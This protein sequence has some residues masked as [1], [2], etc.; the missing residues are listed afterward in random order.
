[1]F[2]KV[3]FFLFL[4]SIA[5]AKNFSV[6]YDPDYAP[7]SYGIDKK[8]YGL[9]VDIWKLWAKKNHHT[10][11]FVQAKD[12]DDA[13]L[14]VKEKKVDFFLGT[15]P[16]EKWMQAS[17]SYYKTKTALYFLK[18]F[19]KKMHTIGIIGDDYKESLQ[20]KLPHSAIISY[21]DYA[22]LLQSLLNHQ[23]DAIYDDALAISYYAIKNKYKHLIKES[24]IISDVSDVQAIAATHNNIQIFNE[25]FGKITLEE[26]EKIE[27]EWISDSSMR[28]YNNANF[29]KK[30][31]F[32]YVYDPDW[33]P[34]EYKDKMS[35]VH[36]GIIA[37]ILSLVSS[38]SGLIFHP[39]A[40]KTW[41]ESV[42]LLKAHKVDMVSAV[43]MTPERK[44]Y[45][46]FSKKNIY[47]Y[48]AVLVANKNKTFA[49][50]EDFND[51]TI[52]VVQGN[53]L[54]EWIQKRFP[55][56]HFIFF[57]NVQEGFEALQNNRIDFFGIN[58]VSATYYINV[59]GFSDCKIY[60]ILNYM[61][62]LKIA[63][64]KSVEP[65]ALALIDEAL[66]NI[67]Q[68]E[69]SDIYHKWTSVQIK[70]ERNYKL[71]FSI[72]AIA[73][74]IVLI[75]LF[76][77]KRLNRLVQKRTA[78]LKELNEHLEDKVIQRTQELALINK[79]MQ[80][81]IKYASLIQNA[82]LPHQKEFIEFFK[83]ASIIWEPKDTVGGDIYFFTPLNEE[84]AFLFVIDCTG[85]G[86]SGAF[87][88]MLLKA[89]EKQLLSLLEHQTLSPAD[90]LTYFN[91]TFKKVLIQ[92]NT[93][94]NV[95]FDAGVLY[96]NKATKQLRFAGANI[97]L[98]YLQETQLHTLKA[99]RHSIGYSASKK[100]Y[101]FKEHQMSLEEGMQFYITTDGFID[102]NGGTKGFPFGKK[103][104]F[105]LLC[106]NAKRPLDTQK[107][108]FLEALAHYQ[109]DEERNDDITLIALQII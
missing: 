60:T 23:V 16:Y 68:K 71:I 41:A 28:F 17:T 107:M 48:P 61:F 73:L 9:F 18:S 40:T 58:G 82:I 22:Q 67:T 12:W 3:L 62:H 93:N 32:R 98:Y 104:F 10:L 109:G 102:Q 57:N 14:L 90:I 84:E 54:G 89:I 31:E 24:R 47:D 49:I 96:I 15:T 2:S 38:K 81:N 39:V 44:K 36:M 25:G 45:L 13:L 92:E 29:L 6:S 43:P 91:H 56:S 79:K 72:I 108:L 88:T 35:H 59:V 106:K 105:E 19:H 33:K 21:T 20:K 55:Q 34:F 51:K 86:V 27:T 26:L 64:L 65:E 100:D 1:V 53:S 94:A 66:A 46:N 77:N 74:F 50:N 76:I 78:E 87:V 30:K 4:T 99:S 70:R 83:D 95:G 8:P 101:T 75:F 5:Y 52:G 80:D 103:R 42:A 63:L 85:H 37:D 69:L 97:S 7:F 11:T